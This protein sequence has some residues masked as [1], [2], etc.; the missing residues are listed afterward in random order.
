MF[1]EFDLKKDSHSIKFQQRP[2]ILVK[3]SLTEL[4]DSKLSGLCPFDDAAISLIRGSYQK[5]RL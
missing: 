5:R 3:L 2:Q 1:G 4:S